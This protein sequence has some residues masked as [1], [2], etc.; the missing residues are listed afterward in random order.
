MTKP[1]VLILKMPQFII[2]EEMPTSR[3]VSMIKL[4]KITM[5]PSALIQSV[6]PLTTTGDTSMNKKGEYDSAIVDYNEAVRLDPEDAT[7]YCG[8][9]D[10]YFLK[11][12]YDRA[13][14]EYSVAIALEPKNSTTYYYNRGCIYYKKR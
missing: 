6:L 10:V 5:K 1:S 8:R 13:I 4:S 2:V 7:A 14:E 3:R 11:G 12:G 9:G